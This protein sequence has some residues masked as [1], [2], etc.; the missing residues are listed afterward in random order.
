MSADWAVIKA[1][2]EHVR[3][4]LLKND[5]ISRER[6]VQIEYQLAHDELEE[7]YGELIEGIVEQV[8]T[9][10]LFEILG[11]IRDKLMAAST[12]KST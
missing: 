12:A 9:D 10:E 3:D 1:E 4:L 7:V 8:V 6:L 2:L 5:L 11:E